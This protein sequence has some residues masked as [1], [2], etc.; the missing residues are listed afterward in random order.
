MA[1]RCTANREK[2]EKVRVIGFLS[3]L[4]ALIGYTWWQKLGLGERER[5]TLLFL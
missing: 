2:I 5:E 3:K 1:E 4:R